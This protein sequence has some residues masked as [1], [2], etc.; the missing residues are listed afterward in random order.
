M[1]GGVGKTQTYSHGDQTSNSTLLA[2]GR[3]TAGSVFWTVSCVL[4]TPG[5]MNTVPV[6]IHLSTHEKV[7]VKEGSS[8][9]RILQFC[10]GLKFLASESTGSAHLCG[11]SL[12]TSSDVLQAKMISHVLHFLIR[13]ISSPPEFDYLDFESSLNSSAASQALHDLSDWLVCSCIAPPSLSLTHRYSGDPRP[14]R[15]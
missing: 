5:R 9:L 3:R 7:L 13:N 14:I 10:S 4:P 11:T 2:S 1:G 8:E 12:P 6:D 15:D